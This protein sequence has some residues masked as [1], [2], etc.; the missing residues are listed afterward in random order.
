MKKK[1]YIIAGSIS[2]ILGF[3]G[4][5][6]PIMPTTPFLLLASFFFTRSSPKL[7]NYLLKNRLLG[8]FLTNYLE[9]RTLPLSN[10]IKTISFLW[11]GLLATIFFTNIPFYVIII[12]I[13][14]G[15]GVSL[16]IGLLGFFRKKKMPNNS[17]LQH[18]L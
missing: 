4:I 14:V 9:H 17:E 13:C 5:F 6:L 18:F 3:I 1:I 7:N 10:K 16:H 15:I 11:C 12:L 8:E 2:T